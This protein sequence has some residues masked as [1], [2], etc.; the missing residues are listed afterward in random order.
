[1]IEVAF[2]ML[3]GAQLLDFAGPHDVLNAANQVLSLR[4]PRRA[5]HYRISLFSERSFLH[6]AGE[7]NIEIGKAK[8]ISS[9][10]EQF[11]TIIVVGGQ[12]LVGSISN[13]AI[14][15]LKA[16]A[17]KARRTVSI[18]TGAF[19]LAAAG[20]L[21]N[22]RAA[23]HWL[24]F[25]ELQRRY[26]KISVD[27]EAIWVKD[28]PIYTSAGVTAG[29]DLTLALVEEDHGKKVSLAAAGGLVVYFRRPGSQSQFSQLL[30]NQWADVN[31]FDELVPWIME[32]LHRD[33]TV[34]ALAAKCAMSER[35]FTRKFATN[36]ATTPAKLVSNLRIERARNLLSDS[37]FSIEQISRKCGFGNSDVLRKTFLRSLE[38]TPNEYR[39]LW[40]GSLRSNR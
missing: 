38:L 34:P 16:S 36:F 21:D 30:K 6:I 39:R 17:R 20:L 7:Q 23:T 8:K 3:D 14:R 15:W 24:Y 25:Q 13:E 35:H 37:N 26:P 32:N 33:L 19:I 5:N 29:I 31:E 40:S 11:D 10:I 1:M 12:N 27:G 9:E 22:R 28:G 18:C 4:H 2:L